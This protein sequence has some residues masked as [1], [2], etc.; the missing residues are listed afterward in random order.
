MR[1][2][3]SWRRSATSKIGVKDLRVVFE[4]ARP[5]EARVVGLAAT[6]VAVAM[7][8]QQLAA[9]L[10]EDHGMVAAARNP[11]RLDQPLLAKISEVA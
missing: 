10:G 5:F 1:A 11:N 7:A 8:L 3:C 4:L 9:S 6:L 2:P